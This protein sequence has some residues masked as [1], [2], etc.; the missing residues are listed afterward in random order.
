[1][2]RPCGNAARHT[3]Q[4]LEA[5]RPPDGFDTPWGAPRHE[6]RKNGSPP[7]NPTNPVLAD[8]PTRSPTFFSFA[9]R[10]RAN[11]ARS[12]GGQKALGTDPPHRASVWWGQL[13]CRPI[14]Q[15]LAK[16]Q[17]A[18]DGPS[19]KRNRPARRRPSK[20]G[21]SRIES[22]GCPCGFFGR[23]HAL[24]WGVSV[25]HNPFFFSPSFQME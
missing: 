22:P 2:T 8:R 9:G 17:N 23:S 12:V 15:S 13:T 18:S 11:R 4:C 21:R 6:S 5:R 20:E 1:L 24:W 14:A 16:L 3:S 7:R 10:R 25:R 19:W